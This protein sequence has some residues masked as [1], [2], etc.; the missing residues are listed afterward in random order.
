MRM[1]SASSS[2]KSDTTSCVSAGVPSGR[3]DRSGSASP[4]AI[5]SSRSRVTASRRSRRRGPV[6][7][8]SSLSQPGQRPMIRRAPLAPSV[9]SHCVKSP[10]I[11]LAACSAAQSTSPQSSG[12]MP[13]CR[14]MSAASS[15]RTLRP[16]GSRNSPLNASPN[17]RS[18]STAVG[19]AGRFRAPPPM[20][21]SPSCRCE[22]LPPENRTTGGL[23]RSG[24][25]H[26]DGRRPTPATPAPA[27]SPRPR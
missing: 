8:A 12:F 3:S 21:R 17:A 5:R 6:A 26:G 2:P 14:A 20:M 19:S 24:R 23:A 9:A 16:S 25:R 11:A 7:Q 1:P 18:S 22:R 27:R 4:R 15:A 10:T 13:V